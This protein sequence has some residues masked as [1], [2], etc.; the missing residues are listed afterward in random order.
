MWSC[1]KLNG[2]GV[3]MNFDRDAFFRSRC[4]WES[5]PNAYLLVFL[6]SQLVPLLVL[7]CAPFSAGVTGF[8]NLLMVIPGF[9]GCQSVFGKTL[10]G[11]SWR[12]D[13]SGTGTIHFVE[14]SEPAPFLATN[15][16][17][18]CFWMGIVASA[19]VWTLTGL[20]YILTIR[21]NGLIA[22]IMYL[23]IAILCDLNCIMF[24][25]IRR[26]DYHA[27]NEAARAVFLTGTALFPHIEPSEEPPHREGTTVEEGEEVL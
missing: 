17:S 16:N 13:F 27:Y 25:K 3:S 24:L 20:Y 22:A 18:N 7:V 11:I 23:V 26:Q 15:L 14:T 9:I 19:I 5:S 1:Q 21:I 10:V 12:F 2:Q 4:P 6:V 8:L